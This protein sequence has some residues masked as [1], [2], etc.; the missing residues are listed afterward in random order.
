LRIEFPERVRRPGPNTRLDHAIVPLP[1]QDSLNP[2][3][4]RYPRKPGRDFRRSYMIRGKSR[5]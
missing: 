3:A 1:A 4:K 2:L 5:A